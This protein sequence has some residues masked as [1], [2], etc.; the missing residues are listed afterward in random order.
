MQ[1]VD[2]T[3][4][5]LNES[6]SSGEWQIKNIKLEYSKEHRGTDEDEAD[7]CEFEIL[8]KLQ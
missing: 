8:R 6:L 1:C 2:G 7:D 4:L 3:C 5:I